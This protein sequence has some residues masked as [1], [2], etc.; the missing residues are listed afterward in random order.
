M[1]KYLSI[2]SIDETT[3]DKAI[4]SPLTDFEDA[5]QYY[6]A[7]SQKVDFIVTRNIKDYKKGKI[8]IITAEDC[9]KLHKAKDDMEV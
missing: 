7:E 4:D 9:V 6:A 1:R 8:K 2:L 5:L 3:V